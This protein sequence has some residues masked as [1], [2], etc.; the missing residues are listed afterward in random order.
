MAILYKPKKQQIINAGIAYTPKTECIYHTKGVN[1]VSSVIA[2]GDCNRVI[3]GSDSRSINV[4]TGEINDKKIKIIEKDG[5]LIGIAGR[6]DYYHN[7]ER[8]EIE[9]M[10]QSMSVWDALAE[11]KTQCPPEQETHMIILRPFHLNYEGKDVKKILRFIVIVS[12]EKVSIIETGEEKGFQALG[13]LH[14]KNPEI[15][16]DYLKDVK[17]YIENDKLKETENG[18]GLVGGDT[19]IYEMLADGTINKLQ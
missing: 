3:I 9:D 11:I 1:E 14:D 8:A 4:K 6:T 13:V 15:T 10:L 12:A 19:V 7:G 17:Q 16:D 18:R 2:I 5:Q